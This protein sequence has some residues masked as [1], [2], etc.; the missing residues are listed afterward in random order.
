MRKN[1]KVVNV[2]G[3]I[4]LAGLAVLC[5]L[6][7]GCSARTDLVKNRPPL[8][9]SSPAAVAPATGS[10]WPGENAGNTLFADNK[11]RRVND[12][13]TILVSENSDGT[14]KAGTNTGR[15]TSTTAGI[16]ALLGLEKSAQNSNENLKPSIQMGGSASNSLKSQG[17]TNRTTKLSTT[18]TARVTKVLENGNLLIEGRRDLTLNGEDQQ[19]VI[20][21]RIRPEDITTDNVIAS[22]FIADASINYS[23]HGIITEKMHTGWL[24]RAMDVVWP[25]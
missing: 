25:F 5:A 7:A 14:S 4:Y 10:I 20:T 2:N 12:I 22:Q 21:G 13:V 23:G 11:A 9:L 18:L 17:D 8:S 1:C 16:G 19:V 6:A 3:K 15:D 24:T